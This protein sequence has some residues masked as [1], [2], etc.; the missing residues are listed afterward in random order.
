MDH[1]QYLQQICERFPQLFKLDHEVFPNKISVRLKDNDGLVVLHKDV[2]YTEGDDV[3][4]L[5]DQVAYD[6]ICSMFIQAFSAA[7]RFMQPQLDKVNAQ[8]N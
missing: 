8:K 5:K 4:A 6:I 2:P 7:K 1:Y 3:E